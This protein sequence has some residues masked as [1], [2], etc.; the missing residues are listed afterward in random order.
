MVIRRVIGSVFPGPIFVCRAVGIGVPLVWVSRGISARLMIGLC[1]DQ[2]SA[3]RIATYTSVVATS[4]HTP[5]F[6]RLIHSACDV[7]TLASHP[8][9]S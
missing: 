1:L 7:A 2:G 3:G 6:C 8:L 5:W 4:G 9:G